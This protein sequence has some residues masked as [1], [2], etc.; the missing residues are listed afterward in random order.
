MHS[1]EKKGLKSLGYADALYALVY[2][3]MS[4]NYCV[5]FLFL[6]EARI[7]QVGLSSVTGGPLGKDVY[8]FHINQFFWAGTYTGSASN[9]FDGLR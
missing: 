5:N 7:N 6:V 3:Q 9:E 8:T 4:H 2:S 1:S